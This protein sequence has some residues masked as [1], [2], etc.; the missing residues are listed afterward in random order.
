[1]AGPSLLL[2]SPVSPESVADMPPVVSIPVAVV[3]MLPVIPIVPTAVSSP[4]LVGPVAGPP[5][6]DPVEPSSSASVVVITSVGVPVQAAR[7]SDSE[8]RMVE[9]WAMQAEF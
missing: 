8:T 7:M 3:V 1:M 5:P 2:P 9:P 6:L 4:G